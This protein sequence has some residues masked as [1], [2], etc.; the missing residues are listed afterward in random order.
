M[1]KWYLLLISALF[2]PYNSWCMEENIEQQILTLQDKQIVEQA[3]IKSKQQQ[4]SQTQKIQSSQALFEY[5]F[6]SSPYGSRD[7]YRQSLQNQVKQA[8]RTLEKHIKSE[9][10]IAKKIDTLQ[11]KLD[12]IKISDTKPKRV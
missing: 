11:K 10:K 12:Q 3:F 7:E 8:K 4:L 5:F 1:N 9:A 6:K 2:T